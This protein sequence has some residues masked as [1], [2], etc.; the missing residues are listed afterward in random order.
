MSSIG[1]E[2][3]KK[4]ESIPERRAISISEV[5]KIL[6]IS[7]QAVY[8]AAKR[9]DLPVIRL[10]KRLLVSS[11]VLERMLDADGSAQ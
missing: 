2:M 5:A 10:G 11:A 9:G 4:Q 1:N 7:R 6:G 3:S 8:L